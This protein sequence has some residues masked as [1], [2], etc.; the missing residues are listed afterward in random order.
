[1]QPTALPETASSEEFDL[2][3]FRKIARQ[4][5]GGGAMIET[6]SDQSKAEVTVVKRKKKAV[7]EGGC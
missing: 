2:Y 5:F 7:A 4:H 6:G 3:S 1:M